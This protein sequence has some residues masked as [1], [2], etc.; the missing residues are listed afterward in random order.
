MALSSM[1]R[2]QGNS[3]QTLGRRRTP[4]PTFAPKLRRTKRRQPYQLW[5]EQ[6]KKIRQANI[7]NTRMMFW[8]SVQGLVWRA[9]ME[10]SSGRRMSYAPESAGESCGALRGVNSARGDERVGVIGRCNAALDIIDRV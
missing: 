1:E 7:H 5:N 4:A 2:F 3:I 6:R 10:A 8:R 9:R